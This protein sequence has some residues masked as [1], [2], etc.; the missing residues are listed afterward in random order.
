[1][2]PRKR[3]RQYA[4]RRRMSLLFKRIRPTRR[5]SRFSKPRGRGYV[6]RYNKLAFRG[7]SKLTAYKVAKCI[8]TKYF[9]AGVHADLGAARAN[10]VTYAA[11]ANTTDKLLLW[12]PMQSMVQFDS[13]AG[14]ATESFTFNGNCIWLK[15]LTFTGMLAT[16]SPDAYMVRFMLWKIPVHPVQ[17]GNFGGNDFQGSTEGSVVSVS[18]RYFQFF[19]VAYPQANDTDQF[20]NHLNPNCGSRLLFS[21]TYKFSNPLVE[22]AAQV[23]YFRKFYVKVPLNQMFRFQALPDTDLH[24]APNFGAFGDYYLTCYWLSG[25]EA[26]GNAQT[27]LRITGLNCVVEF[28]DP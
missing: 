18:Q 19:D 10:L 5:F 22:S 12:A 26:A 7:R 20:T 23:S 2:P 4:R 15:S 16:D 27:A 1:M 21:K 13:A 3:P 14:P 28:K 25:A 17:R 9:H 8:E 11:Q 24:T 6:R